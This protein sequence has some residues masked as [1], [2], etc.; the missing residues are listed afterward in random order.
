MSLPVSTGGG[1]TA[2]A[3]A[4]VVEVA[5]V[6][7]AETAEAA[8]LAALAAAAARPATVG[9]VGIGL[10]G[11]ALASLLKDTA[12]LGDNRREPP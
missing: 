7:A 11:M 9:D 12:L 6:A 1:V 10:S 5:E 4:A 3:A 8:A 2:G